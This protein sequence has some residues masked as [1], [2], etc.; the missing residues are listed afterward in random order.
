MDPDKNGMGNVKKVAILAF[1][2]IVMPSLEAGEKIDATVVNMRFV[3]PV[4]E[5]IILKC[6]IEHDLIVTVEENVIAGGA[7]SACA[8][9]L[10]TQRD[11][12]VKKTGPCQLYHLGLPDKHIDH[13]DP[14]EL[15]SLQG[16]DAEKI[17]SKIKDLCNLLS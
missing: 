1:G 8:E 10:S 14:K 15:L 3:K 17:L 13:G 2:S 11:T 7:G 9:V 12:M 5:A 4:D 6:A 16:L